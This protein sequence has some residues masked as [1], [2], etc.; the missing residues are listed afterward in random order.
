MVS[1]ISILPKALLD[2]LSAKLSQESD[3]TIRS[4]LWF[5]RLPHPRTGFLSLFLPT[6]SPNGSSILEL[7]SVSPNSSRSWF[8][9]GEIL[10]ADGSML[11]MTPIDPVFLLVPIL[12]ASSPHDGSLGNFRT[13]DD[14]LEGA[15]AN[16]AKDENVEGLNPGDILE[17][18]R[19]P[20][21]QEGMRRICDTKEIAFDL[22]VF[23]YS[24]SKFL[25]YLIKKANRLGK[26][27]TVPESRTLERELAKD[28]LMDDGKEELLIS[29]RLKLACD[30]ISQY[31]SPEVHGELLSKF[32]FSA[33]TKHIA[34]LEQMDLANTT[35]ITNGNAQKVQISE[36]KNGKKRK[37][38]GPE[39]AGV[40][41]LKKVNTK[42]MAKL[43]SFFQKKS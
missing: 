4:H 19:L 7:Q 23:R 1:H 21:V 32:D 18:G 13:L 38:T 3:A 27:S 41:K 30:L 2:A 42:G 24:H 16:L 28:D 31:V 9:N 36:D 25:E 8:N 26:G 43:S 17:L 29:G 12:K 33:L 10:L 6:L 15:S 5:L 34:S 20:C 14:I 37:V 11:L 40:A 39:S 35:T 22:V